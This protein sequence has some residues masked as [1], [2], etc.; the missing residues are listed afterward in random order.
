MT[1][2]NPSPTPSPSPSVQPTILEY[3][4]I[5][6]LTKGNAI[7]KCSGGFDGQDDSFENME[8]TKEQV[9]VIPDCSSEISANDDRNPGGD[10]EEEKEYSWFHTEYKWNTVELKFDFKNP[11]SSAL[12]N[13]NVD[14][15]AYSVSVKPPAPDGGSTEP[16]RTY[17]S[18]EHFRVNSCKIT[19]KDPNSGGTWV[20]PND[21]NVSVDPNHP[22]QWGGVVLN[23][24]RTPQD[25]KP[26]EKYRCGLEDGPDK[27]GF[28]EWRDSFNK[29]QYTFSGYNY[30][31]VFD[32]VDFQ[33]IPRNTYENYV[34]KESDRFPLTPRNVDMEDSNGLAAPIQPMNA[35][36]AFVPDPREYVN[37]VYTVEVDIDILNKNGTVIKKAKVENPVITIVQKVEQDT[38][39]YIDQLN[40]IQQYT[41]FGTKQ[42]YESD[43]LSPNYMYDY[44]YTMVANYDGID[45]NFPERRGDDKNNEPLQRGDV[46]IRNETTGPRFCWSIGDIPESVTIV[47]GGSGYEDN[48]RAMAIWSYPT[49]KSFDK[50]L[51]PNGRPPRNFSVANLQAIPRDLWIEIKTKNGKIVSAKVPE[52]TQARGWKD[53]DTIRIIGGK[54]D[55]EL[56]VNIDEGPGWS[57]NFINKY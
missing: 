29:I 52:G 8:R 44:P 20:Y 56:R 35:V 19:S 4:L 51:Y 6:T 23:T 38:S 25:F 46:Y 34:M 42:N 36:T 54:N 40:E 49:D 33:Y 3:G 9:P 14:V 57:R 47:E 32:D 16:T 24:Q 7:Y 55:S 43:E 12:I 10:D 2:S 1:N 50:K 53:G 13:F 22:T 30:V 41:M 31:D 37:V 27:N 18:H 26:K 15:T 39:D 45:S 11:S 21:Y 28:V 17:N 48:D 5:W